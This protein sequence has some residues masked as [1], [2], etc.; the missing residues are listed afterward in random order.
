VLS[1][2]SGCS[3]SQLQG[4]YDAQVSNIGFQSVLQPAAVLP[5]GT[6]T[7]TV[8]GFASNPNSLSGSL[9]GLGRYYFD[10]TGNVLGM[11]VATSTVPSTNLNVGTYSVNVDCSGTVKLT[12]GAA[13]D[14]FLAG[15][16][17]QA[18][19]TRT[20]TGGGGETGVLARSGSCVNLNYPGTFAYQFGGGS[21]QTSTNGAGTYNYSAAGTVSLSG[22]GTFT[23]A[24]SLYNATGLQRSTSS[25]T[26]TVGADCSVSLKFGT[27][28]DAASANF[29]AP[30]SFRFLMLD[31]TNGLL[32]V[33]PDSSTTVTGTLVAQ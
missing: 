2:A 13:Y 11:T 5:P 24:Q 21:K 33:Q 27:T 3:I 9:P 31:A 30:T 7:A 22:S 19:Y 15:N 32:A 8:I 29:V 12:T 10:G 17:S 23:M 6:T 1:A 28:S 14:V 4:A 18:L 16:G 26:Y 20:D 25:G